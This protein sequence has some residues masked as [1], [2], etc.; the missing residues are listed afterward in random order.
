MPRNSFKPV[1]G[2]ASTGKKSATYIAWESMRSRC[3]Y[4]RGPT[5]RHY[6][7]RG[8]TVCARWSSFANFLADM[9]ERPDWMTLDRID[10]DGPYSPEN[11]RWTT[12][13]VQAQNRRTA[14]LVTFRA[15]TQT[16]MEW[17]EEFGLTY[18]TVVY[19]LRRGWPPERAFSRPIQARR[20]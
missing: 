18:N 4:S 8:I 10:N 7:G 5:Y 9:G 16:L 1:H 11:C 17:C 15:R 19:R 12:R 2:H 3:N 13:K 14:H 6:G 20:A